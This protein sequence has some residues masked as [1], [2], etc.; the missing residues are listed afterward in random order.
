MSIQLNMYVTHR[1]CQQA[2]QGG[3][4]SS[5]ANAFMLPARAAAKCKLVFRWELGSQC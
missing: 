1:V 3:F 4:V 2:Q 5:A